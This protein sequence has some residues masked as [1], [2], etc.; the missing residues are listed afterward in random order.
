[1]KTAWS[2]QQMQ[3]KHSIKLKYIHD[4]NSYQNEHKENVST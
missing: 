3:E 2:T 4:K 1:M